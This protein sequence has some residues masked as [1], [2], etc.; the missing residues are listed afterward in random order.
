MTVDLD[1]AVLLDDASIDSFLDQARA[2]GLVPRISSPAAFA[3]QSAMLL[4]KH[5]DS[6]IPVDV[7]QGRLPFERKAISRATQMSIGDF[8]APLPQ[9]EDLIIM[10]AF[11]HRPQ[12]IEDIRGVVLCQ[13]KLNVTRIRKEV[14]AAAHALDM[15]DLWTDIAGLF[16]KTKRPRR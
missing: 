8:S 1:A 5:E 9:P 10:K 11:A 13:P 12:D 4:L 3:R 16:K 14:T 7:A 6:G 2:N 15:P